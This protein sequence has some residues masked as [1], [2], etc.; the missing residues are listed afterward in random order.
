MKPIFF[1]FA[2]CGFLGFFSSFSFVKKEKYSGGKPQVEVWDTQTVKVLVKKGWTHIADFVPPPDYYEN[3]TEQLLIKPAHHKGAV[4]SSTMVKTKIQSG[5]KLSKYV[6]PVLVTIRDSIATKIDCSKKRTYTY[7]E[8]K[9]MQTPFT[10]KEI[11][12]TPDD[13]RSDRIYT[14]EKD[15]LSGELIPAEYITIKRKIIGTIYCRQEEVVTP[16]EFSTFKILTCR[17]Q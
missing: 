15:G 1:L 10:Y 9:K 12:Y 6:P 7:F 3:I 5:I 2:L 11:D 14:L 16:A 4:M 17:K 13:Y 8:R